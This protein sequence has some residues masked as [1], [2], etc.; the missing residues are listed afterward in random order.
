MAIFSMMGGGGKGVIDALPPLTEMTVEQDGANLKVSLELLGK[1]YFPYLN[2]KEAYIL[3][4]K[5]GSVPESPTDGTAYK[6]DRYGSGAEVTDGGG[7]DSHTL[8]LL[9]GETSSDDSDYIVTVKNEGALPRLTEKK[10]GERSLY[11]TGTG[12]MSVKMDELG[13]DIN[14]DW[15]F[16]WWENPS[17]ITWKQAIVCIPNGEYGLIL[18]CP[19][20]AGTYSRM[21]AG[22]TAWD[23]I[24]VTEIGAVATG[25]WV[26]RAIVKSGNKVYSFH[27]GNLVN[28]VTWGGDLVATDVLEIGY[29]NTTTSAGGFNG[30][31][32]EL[33]ISNIARWTANFA[34]PTKAY[35]HPKAVSLSFLD[36]SMEGPYFFR[37]FL[38]SAKGDYQS[39]MIGQAGVGG[40]YTT[41]DDCSWECIKQVA[42]MGQGANL[43]SVGDVKRLQIEGFAECSAFILGF[44]HN[45]DI[46]GKGIHFQ[47][48]KTIGGNN[49]FIALPGYSM[50]KAAVNTG[51]WAS[52][53]MR[54]ETCENFLA[55]LPV[56]LQKV[57]SPCKKFTDNRGYSNSVSAFDVTAT[58]DKLFCLA[59]FEVFGARTNANPGEKNYQRQYEFFANGGSKIKYSVD[60]VSTAIPWLLRSSRPEVETSFCVVS[61][62]G[63]TATAQ[64]N[65]AYGF[66]PC[67]KVGAGVHTV[68]SNVDKSSTLPPPVTG[69][70]ATGGNQEMTVSFNLLADT[71]SEYLNDKAAYIIVVKK[72]S[73]PESP[74]DGD[75]IVK[76]DKTGAVV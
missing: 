32:D 72:G 44:D 2:E 4:H 47:I 26:H 38:K 13:L 43:W 45:E 41:L 63:A 34:V 37:L 70:T 48:G 33:R 59:E 23:V 42:D 55:K 75:V 1:E 30:Y 6:L 60:D 71:Y 73:V 7:I 53:A 50:N 66:A 19:D 51:G 57:I 65:L 8:L 39:A 52:C 56:D 10:F 11:F 24:P 36:L 15:T 22:N 9:H 20:S 17:A 28:T 46:E 21:M 18:G 68:G 58:E 67:F 76:L 61:A 31:I 54:N 27:D 64:A 3:T 49:Q 25:K 12:K 69:L 16:D 5:V 74:T 14:G 29:R 62:A 40:D 35:N